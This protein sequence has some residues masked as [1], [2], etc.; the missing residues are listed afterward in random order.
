MQPFSCCHLLAGAPP[1]PA[2]SSPQSSTWL[3]PAP[4]CP[5]CPSPAALPPLARAG[6]CFTPPL[7]ARR[8]QPA[9]SG[10][11]CPEAGGAPRRWWVGVGP[12]GWAQNGRWGG[13]HCSWRCLTRAVEKQ[14]RAGHIRAWQ[15]KAG[16]WLGGC[17]VAGCGI[18]SQ[19]GWVFLSPA[20][21]YRAPFNHC[22]AMPCHAPIFPFLRP[23]PIASCSHN[24]TTQ[25]PAPALPL[26]NPQT[27]PAYCLWQYL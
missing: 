3:R 20:A 11:G 22:H 15:G 17:L 6:G 4:A 21:S 23:A 8:A 25:C 27:T 2:C 14:G 9:A 18:L 24:P 19:M 10:G 13:E 5:S 7:Q 1:C 16:G 12:Q 26:A